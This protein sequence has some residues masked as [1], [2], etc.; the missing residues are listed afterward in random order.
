MC[1][2]D[3]GLNFLDVVDFYVNFVLLLVDFFKTFAA[4]WIYGIEEKLVTLGP[5]IYF[6]Y[7]GANF[8]S[9]IV[10]SGLWFGVPDNTAR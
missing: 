6:S 9:V 2:T 8:V 3:A 10:A 4:G 5:K 1:C 7:L